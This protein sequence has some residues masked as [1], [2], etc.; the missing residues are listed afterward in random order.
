MRPN[1]ESVAGG[2]FRAKTA[3]FYRRVPPFLIDFLLRCYGDFDVVGV[4]EV[5]VAEVEPAAA[6][7]RMRPTGPFAALGK[8]ELADRLRARSG[9]ARTRP[10]LPL[11]AVGIE[12]ALGIGERALAHAGLGYIVLPL[13]QSRHTQLSP[14]LKAAP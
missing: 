2:F 6:D 12:H 11:L 5:A 14:P 10:I 13:F 9:V 3:R 7:D 1:A 8:L 4:Q